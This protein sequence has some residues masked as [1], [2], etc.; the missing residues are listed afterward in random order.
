MRTLIIAEAGVNHNG[1][2]D[3]ACKLVEVAAEAGADWVKFQTYRSSNVVT[4]KAKKADYQTQT[5]DASETQFEM[6]SR[7]ELSIDDHR[8]L[9]KVCKANSINFF[10]S[11]FDLE[12]IDLLLSLGLT[13]IKI[14]SGEI[15]SIDILEKNRTHRGL[16]TNPTILVPSDIPEELGRR[17]T[18][19]ISPTVQNPRGTQV[20]KQ[21][22]QY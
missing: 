20:S 11:G 18:T 9:M 7:L 3:K 15:T 6:I 8:V 4:R 13:C 22:Q 10:S 5:T 14:P 1:D 12:S 17:Q 2:L 21:I 19:Q 16:T